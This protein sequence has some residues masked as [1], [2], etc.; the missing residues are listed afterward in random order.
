MCDEKSWLKLG[1]WAGSLILLIMGAV[2]GVEAETVVV[3]FAV[4]KGPATYHASGFLHSIS[5][6]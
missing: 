1:A 4:G 2:N 3:D 5:A 6:E